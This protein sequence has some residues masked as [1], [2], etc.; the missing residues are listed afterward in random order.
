MK[1]YFLSIAA[2]LAVALAVAG[3]A[4]AAN[5][6]SPGSAPSLIPNLAP[7]SDAWLNAL[8]VLSV[9]PPPPTQTPTPQPKRQPQPVQPVQATTVSI[10]EHSAQPWILAAQACSAA[11]RQ[12]SGIVVLDFGMPAFERGGYGTLL[13]SGRF[14]KNHK[15]TA[16]LLAYA[17]GYSSCL[18]SGSTASIEI[19]R[20]TSNY[21]PTVPSAYTAGVRWA[22]ETNKLGL[23]L[24][25]RGLSKQVTVAAADDAEPAWDRQFRQTRDFFHGF[26]ASVHGHTLYDYGSLD[27]GVGAIWSARQSWYV[28]GGL[29]YTEA[30]PEIYNSAMA[31][32]WAE[33]A[34][35][36]RGRFHRD[37]HFAGVMTQGTAGC[38][39]GLRPAAA[40]DLLVQA[41]D[42]A[43]VDHVAVPPGGTNIVG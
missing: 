12:E 15:I 35:I 42:S 22:R 29:R 14:A 9:N 5:P 43:G 39:C 20:G 30:L 19:A 26:R 41:L 2:V 7:Q 10:Y 33:L 40:H 13:F 1:R 27:G 36:A 11:K 17:H 34:R 4:L 8:S 24:A 25:Q 31:R 37:V 23:I 16:A 32:E 21:H 38:N 6:P 3:G 18:P 28:A